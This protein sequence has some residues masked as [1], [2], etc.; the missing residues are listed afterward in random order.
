VRERAGDEPGVTD[1]ARDRATTAARRAGEWIDGRR[2]TNAPIGLAVRL[3]ERD[4]AAFG[5]VLG[6]AI[7][8]RLFLFVTALAVVL[9][10][11]LSIFMDAE[12]VQSAIS[13]TGVAAE[14]ASEV[15]QAANASTQRDL[16]FFLSGLVLC[17]AAGRS[18]TRVLA[19]CS[20]GA[21]GMDGRSA[22]FSM[23]VAARV[24]ALLSLLVV[25]AILFARLRDTHGIA[26]AAGSL[27]ANALVLAGSWFF[28]CLAL[29]RAT[30]DPGAAIPGAV[31]FGVVMTAVQWFMTFYL[32]HQIA[33][34]SEV[35]GSIGL[36]VASLGYLFVIG[37]LMAATLVLNA[38]LFERLGSLSELF[39]SLPLVRRI[40]RRFPR[41]QVFFD[42]GPHDDAPPPPPPP[43]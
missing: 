20:A 4:R 32:P 15:E 14:V 12:S 8:L 17:L 37:R 30:R 23:R 41:V 13:S 10:S 31:T 43:T 25:A 33:S 40:P 24:T 18:L 9:I 16:W 34:A 5:S 21:S 35:M 39:F 36:T 28:V 19:A 11:G 3:Y 29:P 27:A 6:S 2:D 42:L 7:A 22:R 1:R 38:V 26:I